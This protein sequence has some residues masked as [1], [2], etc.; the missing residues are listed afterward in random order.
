MLSTSA[1]ARC[2]HAQRGFTL[3]ELMAASLISLI[4]FA[5]LF[6][7][8]IFIAHNVTRVSFAHQQSLQTSRIFHQ[9]ANDIGVATQVVFASNRQLVLQFSDATQATYAYDPATQTL[10]RSGP[11]ATLTLTGITP[12]P[13]GFSSPPLS[14]NVFN[15]YNQSGSS[16]LPAPSTYPPADSSVVSLIDIRQLEL[17][18]MISQGVASSGTLVQTPVVSYRLSLRNKPP[19]G[20]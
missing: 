20:Q 9:L 15:Y 7:A 5:G 8:Y 6:S 13:L 19:L 1:N 3:V 14:T 12:L 16:L 4:V 11:G 2:H 10:Q 17:G 18:F